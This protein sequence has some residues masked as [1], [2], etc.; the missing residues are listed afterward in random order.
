MV[1]TQPASVAFLRLLRRLLA[2]TP[3]TLLWL[4]GASPITTAATLVADYRF[5]GQLKSSV[6]GAPDLILEGVHTATFVPDQVL[7]TNRTVLD[8]GVG[9]GLRAELP[10]RLTPD[11]YTVVALFE[12]AQ[13]NTVT[14]IDVGEAPDTLA[15]FFNAGHLWLNPYPPSGSPAVAAQQYVQVVLAYD[16]GQARVYQDGVKY[17]DIADPQAAAKLGTNGVVHFFRES[18]GSYGPGGRVVRLRLFDGALS[19][20]EVAALTPVVPPSP[21][22]A[23]GAVAVADYRFEGSLKSSVVGAPDLVLQGTAP[24]SFVSDTFGG[25]NRTVLDFGPGSGF[26]L[27][28]GPLIPPDRYSMVA[29]FELS[30]VGT[31]RILDA[32]DAPD[33]LGLFFRIGQLWLNPYQPST[34]PAIADRQYAQVALVNDGLYVRG[35]VDG[36]KVLELVDGDDVAAIGSLNRLFFFRQS[37]GNY[38]AG[39]RVARIRLFNGALTDAEVAGLT[40]LVPPAAIPPSGA[41][42][43]ADYRFE[44]SLKS[45]VIGAP[46]MVL[47]GAA[48]ASFIS[49][50]IGG[51]NRTVLNFG[52]GD[53]LRMDAGALF[54]TNHY[55]MVAL[56]E[57]S[58]VGTARILD[59]R[60]APDTLGLFFRAGQL[61]INPYPPA[62][63]TGVADRQYVQVALV[64]DG[65][66]V[67]G[68]VDGVKV[69]DL[70]DDQNIAAIGN[71]HQLHFFRQSDGGYATGGRV[72]RIRLF[73]G[74]LTG[75]EVAAL[76]PLVPPTSVPAS[77]F[78]LVADYQFHD[79][80]TSSVAGAPAI[81]PTALDQLSFADAPD[82][83]GRRVLKFAAGHGLTLQTSGLVDPDHYTMVIGVAFDS[84]N[85]YVRLMDTKD[86]SETTGWF[87]LYGALGY[88]PTLYTPDP[89]L[90]NGEFGELTLVADG[91]KYRAYSGSEKLFE[92]LDPAHTSSIG[93]NGIVSFFR[94]FSNAAYAPGGR[95]TRIRIYD[96]ALTDTDLAA[97]APSVPGPDLISVPA[98]ANPALAFQGGYLKVANTQALSA[99]FT[100][101][102]WALPTDGGAGGILGSRQPVDSSFDVKFSGTSGLHADIGTGDSWLTTGADYTFPQ[103][104]TNWV[105]QRCLSSFTGKLSLQCGSGSGRP[106]SAERG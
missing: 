15:L 83:S 78:H 39:G 6:A 14:L 51:T 48:V 60:D 84:I 20:T 71:L 62:T 92:L 1:A 61:W 11:H 90:A 67:R 79:N 12:L 85:G 73:N 36:V 88:H 40:T 91:G 59:A 75:A 100:V 105:H 101:E 43:V 57:L 42:V 49:D 41:R 34:A 38:G 32:R 53:G 72:A 89:V 87:L 3:L 97:L 63:S 58:S 21:V 68:Y 98:G 28:A 93:T 52:P 47:E 35:Y 4:F 70:I 31:A 86:P 77:G 64:N 17:L 44:G 46:E 103:P 99:P 81:E 27:D 13:V 33:T 37:D 94:N 9:G 96:G 16:A 106:S 56:F 102:F 82:L 55:T 25:T 95:V 30:S 26:R 76:T 8:F 10:G 66:F 18:G 80:F 19:D 104:V 69:L 65:I 5:E 29:L 22:V 45:S 2:W 50:S 74:A 7:G 24:A 23:S 54:P